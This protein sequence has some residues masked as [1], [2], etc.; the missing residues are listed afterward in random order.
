MTEQNHPSASARCWPLTLWLLLRLLLLCAGAGYLVLAWL[1]GKPGGWLLDFIDNWRLFH[2]D[3]AYRYF[4]VRSAWLDKDLYS[5]SYI[6]PVALMLDGLLAS[7]TGGHLL[8]MRS[9]HALAA[10]ATLALIWATGVRL[11]LHRTPLLLSV[12]IL[13]CMPVFAFG[14]LSFYAENW[15]ALCMALAAH[16]WV[17]NRRLSATLLCAA[18]P[19]IRP[20]GIF[21]LAGMAA[22]LLA[23]RQWRLFILLG[24]PG[25]VYALWL[26]VALPHP[27]DYMQW[28]LAFREI[29]N[30]ASSDSLR[31]PSRLFSTFNLLWWLPT[32][33]AIWHPAIRRLW[34]LCLGVSISL[35]F[36]LYTVAAG[37]AFYEARYV[38]STLPIIALLWAMGVQ[39]LLTWCVATRPR[40]RTALAAVLALF[41]AGE[42]M[43]QLDPLK[44]SVGDRRWPVAGLPADLPSFLR[45]DPA[46]QQAA[47]SL[48]QMLH[49]LSHEEPA[50]DRVLIFNDM[51]FYHLDPHQLR[52][53][54]KVVYAP[55]SEQAADQLLGGAIYGIH[56]GMPKQALHYF[57]LPDDYTRRMVVY[58]GALDRDYPML[59]DQAG[60]RAYVLDYS[61][62]VPSGSV[63]Q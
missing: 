32:L 22:G 55:T 2:I 51:L 10:V 45:R 28:R 48:A 31:L 14:F 35:L 49:R 57:A 3:D 20:E 5:W 17:A 19:L 16:Q 23:L 13:A 47:Q 44:H 9:A 30:L 43:L 62:R 50:I 58:V 61:T 60:L 6:Q 15:L 21:L 41:I 40:T 46:E 37:Y 42:H 24:L 56:P 52:P 39:Q 7:L 54:V 59:F 53:G 34:P 63:L 11:A 4:L 1:T 25:L 38:L 18:M 33:A 27:T 8:A 12:L 26:L 29:L 36:L